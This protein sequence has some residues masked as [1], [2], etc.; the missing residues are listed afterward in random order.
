MRATVSR[1]AHRLVRS[2]GIGMQRPGKRE[3]LSS[4]KETGRGIEVDL[5]GYDVF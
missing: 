4:C 2:F 3:G 5:K 1:L